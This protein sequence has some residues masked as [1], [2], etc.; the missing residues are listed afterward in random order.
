MYKNNATLGVGKLDYIIASGTEQK[1]IQDVFNLESY[2]HLDEISPMQ[3]SYTQA[4]EDRD[5]GGGGDDPS[6]G[7]S[8][9]KE[10][11]SPSPSSSSSKSAASGIE[12]SGDGGGEEKDD[13]SS[14]STRDTD[15]EGTTNRGD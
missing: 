10:S 13:S 4:P 9:T 6:S 3:T 11:P 1:N 15:A 14:S 7:T 8:K 12:P 2:L 5:T